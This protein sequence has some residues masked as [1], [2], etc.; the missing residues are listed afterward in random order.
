M[1]TSVPATK[2]FGALASPEPYV[3]RVLAG[4]LAKKPLAVL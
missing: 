1:W 2:Q 4:D 3:A